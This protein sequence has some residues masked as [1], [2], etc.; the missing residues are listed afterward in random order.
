MEGQINDG[1]SPEVKVLTQNPAGFPPHVGELALS[2]SKGFQPPARVILTNPP[3]P[4]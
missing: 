4:C 2:K 1:K 3:Y